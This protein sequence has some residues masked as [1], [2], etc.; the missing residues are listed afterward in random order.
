MWLSDICRDGED[1]YLKTC[2]Q[3][4]QAKR[5]PAVYKLLRIFGTLPVTTATAE[6]FF[7]H[8]RRLKTYMRATMSEE[9]LTGLALIQAHKHMNINIDN[10]IDAFR[11]LKGQYVLF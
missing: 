5:L 10:I 1:L 6:R 9:R 7:S 11:D 4:A 8:L 3:Q 2:I